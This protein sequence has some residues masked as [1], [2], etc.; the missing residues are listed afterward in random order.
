M[1]AAL[2]QEREPARKQKELKFED[3]LGETVEQAE[4]NARASLGEGL[5]GIDV[6]RDVQDKSTSAQGSAAEETMKLAA[7]RAPKEAFAHHEPTIIQ[8]GQKGTV[9]VNEFE[10]FEA[11]KS[12]RK[13]APRGAQ[14]DRIECTSAPKSGMLG[15]GKKA[16]TWTVYWTAPYIAEVKY[17]MPA[18]VQARYFA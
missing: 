10:E 1:G 2:P 7:E 11:K 8:E 13:G 18:L 9:E 3:F 17:K 6:V 15:L 4:A 12:W 14:M 16:G 5:L